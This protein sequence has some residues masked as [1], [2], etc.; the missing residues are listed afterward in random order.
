VITTMSEPTNNAAEEPELGTEDT[1]TAD[2]GEQL[3]ADHPLVK[4][5]AANK[6][7]IKA[8]RAKAK[9]LDEIEESTKTEAQRL[10]DQLAAETSRA[11]TAEAAMLRY[12]VATEKN[13]PGNA[14][15]F[16]TGVTRD[17]IEASA[18]DVL[19]LIGDAGKP[20]PPQ[21]DPNQGRV[22]PDVATPAGQFAAFLK[23]QLNA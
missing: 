15:K 1:G 18:K 9:R 14:V 16:L 11:D 12:V 8:L 3:P 6:A 22:G 23:Q 2:T 17:E 10:A 19:D 13:I 21:P 20:R 5:L 4:T 7:E